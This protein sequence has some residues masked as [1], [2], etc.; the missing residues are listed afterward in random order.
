MHPVDVPKAVKCV[1]G[2]ITVQMEMMRTETYVQASV[3]AEV[4]IKLGCQLIRSLHSDRN[5]VS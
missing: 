4:C 1:T 3:M 5:N 2:K